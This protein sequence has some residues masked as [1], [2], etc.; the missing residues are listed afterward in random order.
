MKLIEI[1]E[2][3]VSF[4]TVSQR[5]STREIADFISNYCESKG[6]KIEQ[7]PYRNNNDGLEKVNVVARKGGQKSKLAFSGHM[8]T[9]PFNGTDWNTDPLKLTLIN[10]KY[11]GMGIADMKL[12]IAIAMK[13]GE[14]IEESELKYPFAL[15]F[16]SDEE[17]GCLGARQLIR[18]DKIHVA[19]SIIIGEPTEMTPL[20]LHKG[21]MFIRIKLRGI[22][23]HASDPRNGKS[24]VHLVLVPVLQKLR[25][26]ERRVGKECRSRWSPY[27]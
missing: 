6:F 3:L 5:S 24:V 14:A 15:C 23:G 18:Q 7:Y 13:A 10:K 2:K 16:T 20:N 27:H 12:F 8:D 9:V 26:E 1:A 4:N 19:D 17:V 11:F 21:Y 22:T 25:S